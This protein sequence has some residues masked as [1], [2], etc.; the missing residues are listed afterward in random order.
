MGRQSGL[1]WDAIRANYVANGG[2]ERPEVWRGT[3]GKKAKEPKPAAAP[4]AP[5]ERKYVQP[6][7]T[8]EQDQEARKL[9]DGGATCPELAA[10]YFVAVGTIRKAILR[11][12]G[13]L[14][15]RKDAAILSKSVVL[16]DADK[17]QIVALYKS[18]KGLYYLRDTFKV[19]VP[20]VRE[21]LADRGVPMHPDGGRRK[22]TPEQEQEIRRVYE[23][24]LSMKAT[25]ERLGFPVSST[26]ESLLRAGGTLR[27]SK[28]ANRKKSDDE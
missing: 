28:F 4:K 21:L 16:T 13:S 12:G 20:R 26:R 24:G 14:R 5:T 1:D 9:Y 2:E 27:E 15:S 19:G 8:P 18:G 7:L 25:A 6:A 22:H 3:T 17:D 11:A 10:K 23:S